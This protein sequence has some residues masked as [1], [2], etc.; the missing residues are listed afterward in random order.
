MLKIVD[1]EIKTYYTGGYYFT[2]LFV[3]EKD[4]RL[5]VEKGTYKGFNDWKDAEF[6][7]DIIVNDTIIELKD[8]NN[9][10]IVEDNNYYSPF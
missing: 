2:D 5:I 7:G 3:T 4:G 1:C 9:Q 8:E 6:F 10:T